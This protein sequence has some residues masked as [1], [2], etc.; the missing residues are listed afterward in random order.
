[1]KCEVIDEVIHSKNSSHSDSRGQRV[2]LAK[3]KKITLKHGVNETGQV[4]FS[5]LARDRGSPMN[6]DD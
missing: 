5:D 4:F 3:A 1:V 2:E 6:H